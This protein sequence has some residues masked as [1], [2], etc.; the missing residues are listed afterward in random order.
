MKLDKIFSMT[1]GEIY[2]VETLIG[3]KDF[4]EKSEW[5]LKENGRNKKKLES[6]LNKC[7]L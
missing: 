4:F 1:F 5:I 6:L 2:F 3:E 7:L